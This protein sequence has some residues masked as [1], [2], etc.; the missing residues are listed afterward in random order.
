MLHKICRVIVLCISNI[1]NPIQSALRD[2]SRAPPKTTQGSDITDHLP[3]QTSQ[4]LPT[5]PLV[6]T[7][8]ESFPQTKRRKTQGSMNGDEKA[9]HPPQNFPEN[10]MESLAEFN[11]YSPVSAKGRRSRKY[12]RANGDTVHEDNVSQEDQAIELA[13]PSTTSSN[14]KRRSQSLRNQSN[15]HGFLEPEDRRNSLATEAE[16]AEPMKD[17]PVNKTSTQDTPA[18]KGTRKTRKSMPAKLNEAEALNNDS[19]PQ[20][21]TPRRGRKPKNA[22]QAKVPNS[23][24]RANARSTPR[25]LTVSKAS[26]NQNSQIPKPASAYLPVRNRRGRRSTLKQDT[27]ANTNNTTPSQPGRKRRGRKSIRF[28]AQEVAD[29]AFQSPDS[30]HSS[31]ETEVYVGDQADGPASP[32]TAAARTSRRNRKPTMRAMESLESEKRYRRRKGAESE[33]A[34]ASLTPHHPDL[35]VV[36]QRLFELAAEAVSPDFVATPDAKAQLM[37]FKQEYW[38]NKDKAGNAET[39][40]ALVPVGDIASKPAFSKNSQISEPWTDQN[41]W[42]HTGHVNEHGEEYL[43]VPPELELYRPN[44]TYGDKQLPQPPIRLMPRE[45]LDKDRIY[46]FPPRMGQRNLP[47]SLPFMFENVDEEV[48]KIKAR[49]EARQHG[50][51]VDRFLSVDAIHALIAQQGPVKASSPKGISQAP[52]EVR[53]RRR[54]AQQMAEDG[55][56]VQPKRRRR[57]QPATAP[58][59]PGQGPESPDK[60]TMKIKLKLGKGTAE[61]PAPKPNGTVGRPR[62]RRLSAMSATGETPVE[63]R[64]PEENSAKR[65]RLS[66]SEIDSMANISTTPAPAAT[67][68]NGIA[69]DTPASSF[70]G[71]TAIQ[72]TEQESTDTPGGRPRRAAPESHDNVGESARKSSMRGRS[73]SLPVSEGHENANAEQMVEAVDFA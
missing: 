31:N 7:F 64:E 36:A 52:R 1:S 22:A 12:D 13:D 39:T 63:T 21:T 43:F 48:A 3:S 27:L 68:G 29:N 34:L 67:A 26:K 56:E 30:A 55:S 5:T 16:L 72:Q 71:D 11:D 54:T 65:R 61:S 53:R 4:S 57:R 73:A 24:S 51:I 10:E 40:V 66:T 20:T 14:G 69:D 70:A 58:S 28:R 25:N 2:A 62:K 44:N 15:L 17:K 18:T 37:Q 9:S 8:E 42:T 45:Q 19:Q 50:I 60:K 49:Q 23:S 47:Q 59:T 32:N 35:A 6:T 46:G 33:S 41:G 38:A